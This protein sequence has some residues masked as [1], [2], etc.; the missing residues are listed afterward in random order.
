[1]LLNLSNRFFGAA[2]AGARFFFGFRPRLLGNATLAG[3]CKLEAPDRAISRES[4]RARRNLDGHRRASIRCVMASR[5]LSLQAGGRGIHSSV[6]WGPKA[7]GLAPA[8]EPRLWSRTNSFAPQPLPDFRAISSNSIAGYASALL[9]FALHT[10][11]AHERRIFPI[12]V[13]KAGR[14]GRALIRRLQSFLVT[15]IPP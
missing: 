6:C 4:G 5:G 13:E 3:L 12:R 9:V 2:V 11:L 15:Q 8:C 14:L 1:M 7:T 10:G